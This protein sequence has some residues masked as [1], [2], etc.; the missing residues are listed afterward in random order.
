MAG[1]EGAAVGYTIQTWGSACATGLFGA[2]CVQAGFEVKEVMEY[3]AKNKVVQEAVFELLHGSM[4]ITGKV[5]SDEEESLVFSIPIVGQWCKSYNWS[6]KVFDT[7]GLIREIGSQRLELLRHKQIALTELRK[8][9]DS[10]ERAE[11]KLE[12]DGCE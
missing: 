9:E 6:K 12:D 11:Q 8:I 7:P 2:Q 3:V 4:E 5:L 10:I 1:I